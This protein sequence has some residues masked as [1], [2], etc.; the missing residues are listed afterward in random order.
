MRGAGAEGAGEVCSSPW[1]NVAKRS[2]AHRSLPCKA[3]VF[4]RI[5]RSS[6]SCRF[7]RRSRRS[8]SRSSL[9]RQSRRC[10]ASSA[11]RF[12]QFRVPSRLEVGPF[13]TSS[14]DPLPELRRLPPTTLRHRGRSFP[15]QP[16]GIHRVN[17][18]TADSRRVEHSDRF[19]MNSKE[20]KH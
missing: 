13:R 7:S 18:I 2:R 3:A 10:P 16:W 15:P 4:E 5:A 6:Q 14:T 17:S 1:D 9:V 20:P 19:G 12:I 8:S 11:A